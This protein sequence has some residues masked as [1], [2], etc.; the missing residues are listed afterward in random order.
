[1]QPVEGSLGRIIPIVLAHHEKFDG[2]GYHAVPG[3]QIPIEAR[4]LAV[5]DAY[6]TLTSDR[7]YRRAV[8]PF[9]AK[10]I[11]VKGKGASFDPT[12]VDAFAAA[13]DAGQMDLPESVLVI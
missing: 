9:E 7:P 8:T 13:F 4:V 1:M 12:V 3:Q 10:A 6:D 5:A 11:I 2:S